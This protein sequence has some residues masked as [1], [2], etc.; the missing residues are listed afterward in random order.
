MVWRGR[1]DPGAY[2]LVW[3]AK[4]YG[5]TSVAF[6]IVERDGRLTLGA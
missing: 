3:G 2:S 5:L 4:G 6:E 1:L